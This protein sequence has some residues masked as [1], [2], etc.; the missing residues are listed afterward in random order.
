[1]LRSL[2]V[3]RFALAIRHTERG[4]RATRDKLR[5]LWLAKLLSTIIAASDPTEALKA[6]LGV[7]CRSTVSAMRCCAS[8][9]A[10]ARQSRHSRR[11]PRA[12]SSC[13]HSNG[14]AHSRWGASS[15][16]S[17]DLARMTQR[18]R[19]TCSPTLDFTQTRD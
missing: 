18:V 19:V 9:L 13:D 10:R 4:G 15:S 11:E 16:T 3:D 8:V 2:R 12:S 17:C 5:K 6:L 7:F 1:M 14:A